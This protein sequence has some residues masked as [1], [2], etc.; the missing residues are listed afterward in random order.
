M[1]FCGFVH[2]T[3]IVGLSVFYLEREVVFSDVTKLGGAH[4]AGPKVTSQTESVSE[5]ESE[6][7]PCDG[8]SQWS[9]SLGC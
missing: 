7:D 8:R 2:R 9:G 1:C 3:G 6:A 4:Q 5:Q